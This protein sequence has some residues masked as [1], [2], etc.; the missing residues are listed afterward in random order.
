MPLA[1]VSPSLFVISSDTA[2]SSHRHDLAKR[3]LENLKLLNEIRAQY[4]VQ[5]WLCAFNVLRIIS[6]YHFILCFSRQ[7][8]ANFPAII[9]CLVCRTPVFNS[10]C[11]YVG[12]CV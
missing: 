8:L 4:N 9:D 7:C 12:G 10:A 2:S 11:G 3:L 1:S 6:K 5:P